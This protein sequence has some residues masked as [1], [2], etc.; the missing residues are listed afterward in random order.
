MQIDI[1]IKSSVYT[2]SS[3]NSAAHRSE[4]LWINVK[5]GM[6]L[7]PLLLIFS[8]SFWIPDAPSLKFRMAMYA[9]LRAGCKPR[10]IQSKLVITN[11]VHHISEVL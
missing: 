9:L 11:I 5:E 4:L 10:S 3:R 6:F 1:S 7:R 2:P 8:L